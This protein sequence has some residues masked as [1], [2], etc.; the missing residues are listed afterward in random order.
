MN[1]LLPDSSVQDLHKC[2][3]KV[4]VSPCGN[5]AVQFHVAL[6]QFL[7]P[8]ELAGHC[9]TVDT[10][11]DQQELV[12]NGSGSRMEYIWTLLLISSLFWGYSW[13]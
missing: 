13:M 5:D 1:F 4:L 9:E 7:V 10:M 2:I 6:C 12:D 3:E 11:T 8:D